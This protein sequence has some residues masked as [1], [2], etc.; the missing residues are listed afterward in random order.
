MLGR[1]KVKA[2]LVSILK[3]K[4]VGTMLA[5]E[6]QQRDTYIHTYILTYRVSLVGGLIDE[7]FISSLLGDCELSNVMSVPTL[8]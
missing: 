7:Y 3:R 4:A 5:D 6:I 1:T 8:T 2:T